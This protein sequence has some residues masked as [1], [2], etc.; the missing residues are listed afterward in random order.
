M[1]PP[2]VFLCICCGSILSLV[3]IY[4]PLFFG[5]VM[6]DNSF[7]QRK[8]KL[9][10]RITLNHNIFTCPPPPPP[11]S[12]K[13]RRHFSLQTTKKQKDWP[14]GWIELYIFFFQY[15]VRHGLTSSGNEQLEKKRY[16]LNNQDREP[17]AKHR[18][19]RLLLPSRVNFNYEIVTTRIDTIWGKK[20]F[21][22]GHCHEHTLKNS[23]TQKHVY[24]VENLLTVVKF[25]YNYYTSVL[26]LNI[27]WYHCD[28]IESF[29]SQLEKV[30][31]TF[32]SSVPVVWKNWWKLFTVTLFFKQFTRYPSLY[33]LG[34]FP[35]WLK[36]L[37]RNFG[38][39]LLK[40]PKNVRDSVPLS[41]FMVFYKLPYVQFR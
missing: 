15:F 21:L 5:M 6:Y 26:K 36:L 41:C 28:T 14:Y 29:R 37:S 23:T 9:E 40:K 38:A 31:L 35:A 10:P 39:V 30:S 24:T 4:F 19:L 3:Q 16:N 18:N 8:I 12:Q 7:K 17:T 32:S 20:M 33:V 27:K 1:C 2:T 11:P 22:K 25:S 34:V 13:K